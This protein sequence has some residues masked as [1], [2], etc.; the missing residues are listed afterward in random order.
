MPIIKIF[1]N[2]NTQSSYLPM[3]DIVG[4]LSDPIIVLGLFQNEEA[5]SSDEATFYLDT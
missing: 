2:N 4:S 1:L 5:E 3:F